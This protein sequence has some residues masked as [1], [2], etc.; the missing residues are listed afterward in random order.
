VPA[1][2][3]FGTA[4]ISIAVSDGELTTV[5]GFFL[6]VT[7]VNDAPIA[8]PELATTNEDTSQ[9]ITLS[10][11]DVD[12]DALTYSYT[13]PAHG[14]LTGTGP[15]VTYTPAANYNGLDSFSFKA[16]DGTVDSDIATVSMSV[17]P[18]NDAPV[19][20]PQ[21]VITNEDTS[22]SFTL[23]GN[24]VDNANLNYIVI[25]GPSHGTLTGGG[26][27]N[28]IYTPTTNYNGPDSFTFR[29]F[30]GTAA[31]NIAS[32]SITVTPVNDAPIANPQLVAT[33]E[34]TARAITLS[35]N[36]VDGDALTYSIVSGPFH[37]T[38]SGT[39]SARTYTPVANYNGPDS[40]MFSVFDGTAFSNIATV[41]ISVT[42]V[43]DNPI[44]VNDTATVKK[45]VSVTI[46][47]LANDSDVEGD[48]LAITSASSGTKG[49]TTVINSN[50]TVTFKPRNGFTGTDT[51]TYTI[52]DGQGGTATG[53]VTVRVNK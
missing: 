4:S 27:A 31:S 50:G 13:Q 41:S 36:D 6:T 45:N 48:T 29:I 33:N 22:R 9:A 3:Q 37:G 42:P 18:V 8:N 34:D 38:L 35:A 32:V 14:T 2:N 47:V 46:A 16:N 24:D 52:S 51:F 40:F 19:A 43:N 20:N 23:S 10:A 11:T 49:G 30:D 28:R 12:G 53:T 39:G 15:N 26:T 44:V 25:S 21:Q 17:T 7:A 1:A 5:G